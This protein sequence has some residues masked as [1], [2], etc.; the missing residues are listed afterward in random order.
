LFYLFPADHK[1]KQKSLSFLPNEAYIF[2]NR[3][4][5]QF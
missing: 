5:N 3:E 2:A 1:K 4:S